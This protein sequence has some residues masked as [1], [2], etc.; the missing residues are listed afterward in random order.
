MDRR[1][2]LRRRLEALDNIDRPAGANVHNHKVVSLTSGNTA[3]YR[4]L[5][6]AIKWEQAGLD[7]EDAARDGAAVLHQLSGGLVVEV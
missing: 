6:V 5:A 2:K 7:L 1:C 4:N 3:V